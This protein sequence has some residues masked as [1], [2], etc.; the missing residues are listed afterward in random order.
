M[1]PWAENNEKKQEFQELLLENMNTLYNLAYRL[2][3]NHASA[4]DLVQDTSLRAYRFYHKYEEGTNFRGWACTILR[5]I[6]INDYRKRKKEPVKVT[7]EGLENYIGAPQTTGFEDEIFGEG[8]QQSVD[9]LPEDLRTVVT[10][11]YV[12][13][14]AYKEIADIVKCP[15][16]TVMSRL[17]MARQVLKKK[18][19]LLMK[20]EV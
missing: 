4:K 16:G 15:I 18:L 19:T 17:Y 20:S 8:L 13:G 7:Y 14:F 6:F 1:I 9:Q 3:Q 5:N 11:F 2:T 10:L 12:E